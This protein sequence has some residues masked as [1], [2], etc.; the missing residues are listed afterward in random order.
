MLGIGG[1]AFKP[2]PNDG[3]INKNTPKEKTET[4]KYGFK[5]LF[6]TNTFDPARPYITQLNPKAI[7]FVQEYIAR[8]GDN[9]E[10]MKI[11]GKPYFD[12]YDVILSHYGLPKELKYLSVIESDLV[13]H[14]VSV[15]GAVGPWQIMPS[16]AR[17]RGLTVN[18]RV[19]ERTNFNKSTHAAAK[20]LKDLYTQFDDWLLVIAA[21]NCGDGRLRQAIKKSG[22]SNFWD[23]QS[24][25]PLETRNHV[26]RFIGTHYIFEGSGGLT[27]MTADEVQD[28]SLH[29]VAMESRKLPVSEDERSNTST[30]EVAG[31]YISAVLAKNLGVD[32]ALFN[33][34]NPNFDKLILAG[35]TYTMRLPVDKILLFGNKKNTILNESVQYLLGGLI[36]II[37]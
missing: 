17:S 32:I 16:E 23:L 33:K 31:K 22:S 13:S 18:G 30:I 7:P 20:I 2:E 5:S 28:Y 11:W 14:A 36:S 34:F 8:A 26:K 27:T 9:F 12:I 3:D 35:N 6:S 37:K 21:Y 4:D 29:A 25:L 1:S 19:D 15:A 24:Y 10:K